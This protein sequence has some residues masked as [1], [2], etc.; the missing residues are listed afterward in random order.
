M[1]RSRKATLAAALL[2]IALLLLLMFLRS[3]DPGTSAPDRSRSTRSST[4]NDDVSSSSH[5]KRPHVDSTAEE[6]ESPEARHF[7]NFYL[8]PIHFREEI[9]TSPEGISRTDLP[10]S[11]AAAIDLVKAKYNEV[12]LETKEEPLPL[13]VDLRAAD[14]TRPVQF[15]LPRLPVTSALRL[16]AGATGNRLKGTGPNF[17]FE[18]IPGGT[19][20]G[21]LEWREGLLNTLAFTIPER[22]VTD[23]VES[24]KDGRS[25]SY[26]RAELSD[27][28]PDNT[29]PD[30]IKTLRELGLPLSENL[31]VQQATEDPLRSTKVEHATASDLAILNAAIE[32]LR[33]DSSPPQQAK[34]SATI[35]ELP[36]GLAEGDIRGGSFDDAAYET[37]IQRISSLEGTT[38]RTL[39]SVTSLYGQSST[40]DLRAYSSGQNPPQAGVY[41]D[42]SYRPLGLGSEDSFTFSQN[43]PTAAG[44]TPGEPEATVS[45]RTA[46]PT[47]NRDITMT[48]T[49]DG[50]TVLVVRK[51]ERLDPSGRPIRVK[52]AP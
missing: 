51:S 23:L 48:R 34:F 47:G 16:I 52:D 10:V 40:I 29:P 25:T 44:E 27:S 31:S 46:V 33:P 15:H 17:A 11:L 13:E 32:T 18:A 19:T 42:F 35:I 6:P 14:T 4:A 24:S 1:S 41:L 22:M 26:I 36:A 5:R 21:T 50:R 12:A 30:L 8:R 37:W 43:P 20:N 9:M 39:P 7:R 45:A 2:V 49:A 38:I 28:S 3:G